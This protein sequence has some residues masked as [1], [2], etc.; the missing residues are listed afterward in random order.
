MVRSALQRSRAACTLV[1]KEHGAARGGPAQPPRRS[2]ERAR[3]RSAAGPP[4]HAGTPRPRLGC[5]AY[6]CSKRLPC[7]A[8]GV[9]TKPRT[10]RAAAHAWRSIA[11]A[12]AAIF[13]R[14]PPAAEDAAG[15][16]RSSRI[17]MSEQHERAQARTR[18]AMDPAPQTHAT[19]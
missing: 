12:G 14:A 18:R 2:S 6:P 11:A 9:A 16:V 13:P 15:P 4:A 17:E 7:S 19:P 8:G 5:A 10:G 1:Q 3:A